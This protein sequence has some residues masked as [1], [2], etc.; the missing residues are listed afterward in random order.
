MVIMAILFGLVIFAGIGGMVW[1]G[2]TQFESNPVIRRYYLWSIPA[3]LILIAAY[4]YNGYG[5]QIVFAAVAAGLPFFLRIL[6][7]QMRVRYDTEST[8]FESYTLF[9]GTALGFVITTDALHGLTFYHY[10]NTTAVVI[11]LLIT[12][13]TYYAFLRKLDTGRSRSRL[14]SLEAAVVAW[15]TVLLISCIFSAPLGSGRISALSLR[16]NQNNFYGIRNGGSRT[17]YY[18]KIEDPFAEHRS[19]EIEVPYGYFHAVELNQ[20]LPFQIRTSLIGRYF[21]IDFSEAFLSARERSRADG[22]A[23]AKEIESINRELQEKFRKTNLKK[24]E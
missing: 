16:E 10:E 6:F 22:I 2:A 12:G 15:P 13:L 5:H 4:C 19:H 23:R 11:S 3:L 14:S 17:T 20:H 24:S 7:R 1:A 21:T 8:R 18:I 9:I